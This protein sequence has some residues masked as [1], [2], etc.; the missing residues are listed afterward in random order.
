MLLVI[1]AGRVPGEVGGRVAELLA[2]ADARV[3]GVVLN[4]GLVRNR[5]LAQNN[6]LVQNKGLP[7]S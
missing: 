2:T 4:K 1:E 6:G 3:L 5:G 7:C